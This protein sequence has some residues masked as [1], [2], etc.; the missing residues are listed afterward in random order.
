MD[1]GTTKE[2]ENKLLKRKEVTGSLAFTGATPSN[3]QLQEALAKK[4][5]SAADAIEVKHIYGKF[6]ETTANF[7]AYVYE[8][9]EQHDKIEP[10]K[11]EKKQGEQAAPAA[12]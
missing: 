8:S 3:A 2:K 1:L 7:E 4:Y 5:N 9:K 11:K 10:K 6:G 12:K